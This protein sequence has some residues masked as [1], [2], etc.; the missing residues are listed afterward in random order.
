[1]DQEEERNRE[2]EH[3][4]FVI[5]STNIVETKMKRVI[6]AFINP[7]PDRSEFVVS[8]LLNNA[9]IPFGA[10]VK[11]ILAIAKRLF[12]RVDRNAFHTLLSRRNAFAHQDHL[13]SIRVIT[14]SEDYPDV[15]FVVESIKGSGE[16]EIVTQER[17]F[18]EFMEAF[19]KV[20]EYLDEL[21]T[22][23]GATAGTTR[24]PIVRRGR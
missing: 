16:L 15:S 3:L 10:K 24:T 9:T 21:L 17:V 1:M 20:D 11:V 12:V 6:E 23:L 18:A 8:Y 4:I 22:A 14:D 2:E 13:S 19:I 7:S 5:R